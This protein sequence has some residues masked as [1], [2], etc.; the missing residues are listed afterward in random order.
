MTRNVRFVLALG[1][2]A[3][4][5][6]SGFACSENKI[7]AS[8]SG[9][10]PE[11]D[12]AVVEEEDSGLVVD[13]D[14]AVVAKVD[15]AKPSK[16][17]ITVEQIDVGTEL[18]EYALAVPKTY[19][20]ARKYPL[21]IALHGDG[22]N[23]PGVATFLDFQ[24]V[25]GDDAIVAYPTGAED[26]TTPYDQNP[27]QLLVEATINSV[28]GKL[29][30]DDTKVWGFGYSKGGFMANE[31]ACRKPGIFKAM[32]VHASG[33][34][35]EPRVNGYPDCPGVVGLPVL[36][37]E[38][39]RDTGIGGDYAAKYWAF[40]NGCGTTRGN[41]TADGCYTQ[42]GCPAGKPVI[43]CL[44]ANVSHYPIWGQATAVSWTWFKTL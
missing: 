9:G 39:D 21:I 1:A 36:A 31:I 23:G 19:D 5:V 13:P 43:Y 30:I 6:L 2:A 20:A 40:V 16:V 25:N 11:A 38:G 15:S 27:D 7:P 10:P 22:Q 33:A 34:P 24:A 14:G 26:L 32:A 28:K 37:T 18:R 8:S 44:A 12:G 4:T 17:K 29:S 42:N 41:P 35:E 3:A